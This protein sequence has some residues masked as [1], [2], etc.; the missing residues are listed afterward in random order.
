MRNATTPGNAPPTPPTP[1]SSSQSY[2][3]S[4][5][6]SL[7]REVVA[8]LQAAQEMLDSL[9]TQNQQLVKQNQQMRQE[10]ENVVH[11]AIHLQKVVDSWEPMKS[12]GP[13]VASAHANLPA[14]PQ[15]AK[16]APPRASDRGP[17]PGASGSPFAI[18]EL[19]RNAGGSQPLFTEQRET[20]P[21]T[22]SRK[23]RSSDTNG[24]WLAIAVILVVVGAFAIGYSVVRPLLMKQR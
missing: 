19:D 7:Y 16:P 3:P 11:S 4:V 24:L 20:R 23:M 2:S 10:I 22:G 14:E 17:G 9:N 5:P 6:I 21:R 13:Q 15:G 1:P 18:D 8:E 12:A